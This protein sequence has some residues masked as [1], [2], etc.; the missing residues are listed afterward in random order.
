MSKEENKSVEDAAKYF[1]ETI[2]DLVRKG[3]RI[4][5]EDVSI[6]ASKVEI[7]SVRPSFKG[8]SE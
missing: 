3:A 1:L 7:E 8:K 4:E 5:L 2:I 6:F